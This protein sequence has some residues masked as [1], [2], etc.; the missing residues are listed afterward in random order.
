MIEGGDNHQMISFS[1]TLT[2]GVMM[3]NAVGVGDLLHCE[4][5]SSSLTAFWELIS[6]HTEQ[7]HLNNKTV[8]LEKKS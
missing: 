7:K 3:L 8:V 5:S 6:H 4:V 1:N 2:S